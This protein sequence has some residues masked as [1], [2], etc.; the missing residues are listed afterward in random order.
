MQPRSGW[1]PIVTFC[2]S[3]FDDAEPNVE[4]KAFQCL[5][6][7]SRQPLARDGYCSS[8][9]GHVF[10]DHTLEVSSFCLAGTNEIPRWLLG[11]SLVVF[12]HRSSLSRKFQ[13]NICLGLFSTARSSEID[14]ENLRSQSF[15]ARHR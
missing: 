8:L 12:I 1:I 7:V 15:K 2:T 10:D 5:P 14:D 3:D 4:I 9:Y 13:W 11:Y 6:C